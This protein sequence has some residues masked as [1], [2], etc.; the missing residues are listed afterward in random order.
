MNMPK[1]RIDK[2]P[3][4]PKNTPTVS[5]TALAA[6]LAI[7]GF[8]AFSGAGGKHGGELLLGV[9]V[10]NIPGALGAIFGERAMRDIRN[11]TV[12]EKARQGTHQAIQEAGVVTRDGPAVQLGMEGLRQLLEANT[13]ATVENTVAHDTERQEHGQDES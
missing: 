5:L 8:L 2:D 6:M 3:K 10:A 1:Y 9:I 12:R 4:V 13:R 11:G 7:G